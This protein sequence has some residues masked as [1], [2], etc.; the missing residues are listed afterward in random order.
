MYVQP[1]LAPG[2]GLDWHSAVT[3]GIGLSFKLLCDERVFAS[4]AARFTDY[5]PAYLVHIEYVALTEWLP[6]LAHI[7]ALA[8]HF[9]TS[10]LDLALDNPFA[11]APIRMPVT[12]LIIEMN[13]TLRA[14]YEAVALAVA[15]DASIVSTNCYLVA[16]TQTHARV[17]AGSPVDL[18]LVGTGVDEAVPAVRLRAMNEFSG[19]I[20]PNKGAIPVDMYERP[21]IVAVSLPRCADRNKDLRT[22]LREA[23][24]D[25]VLPSGRLTA[26]ALLTLLDFISD[27]QSTATE[28]AQ[29]PSAPA[30]PPIPG[31]ST[32]KCLAVAAAE[33]TRAPT[34]LLANGTPVPTPLAARVQHHDQSSRPT[35]TSMGGQSPRGRKVSG[36]GSIRELH[37]AA[38]RRVRRATR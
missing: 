14:E 13:D 8:L 37:P 36:L 1:L 38:A 5:S 32:S 21:V 15:Q 3:A 31:P 35:P 25:A 34:L 16:R 28:R 26:P 23:G 33:A 29:P 6:K 2:S 27:G 30:A 24:V 11:R 20:D 17:E 10:L 19:A 9:R 12:I 22:Q 18:I 7:H 4:D